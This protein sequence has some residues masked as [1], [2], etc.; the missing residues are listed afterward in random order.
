MT[1]L[2]HKKILVVEDNEDQRRMMQVALQQSGYAITGVSGAQHALL[3]AELS[4][5]DLILLDLTLAS[6]VDGWE[7][8][9]RLKANHQTASIPVMMVSAAI[10]ESCIKQARAD[11]A[12]D[13]LIKPFEISE[14]LLRVER[15]LASRSMTAQEEQQ[16][17]RD[18]ENAGA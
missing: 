4:A 3:Y 10:D 15:I 6:N 17:S 14:L 13:Y 1:G 8:L 2:T 5:P 9:K 7:V 12:D 11:G 18:S 16:F